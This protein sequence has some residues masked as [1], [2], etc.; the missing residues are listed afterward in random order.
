M[1]KIILIFIFL[2]L[3][4]C[5]SFAQKDE[6]EP[7][8]EIQI[9]STHILYIGCIRGYVFTK[10]LVLPGIVLNQ[11]WK[12]QGMAY[13]VTCVDYKHQMNKNKKEF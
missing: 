2:L 10:T 11:L 13:L 1:Q 9:D 5:S 12:G 3:F 6:W 4:S 7:L 8:D